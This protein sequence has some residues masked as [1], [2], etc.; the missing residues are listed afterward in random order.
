MSL[1]YAVILALGYIN[2]ECKNVNRS[3]RSK[4]YNNHSND[5]P[6]NPVKVQH[7][8]HNPWRTKF[9]KFD[10]DNEEE[11]N[12]NDHDEDNVEEGEEVLDSE[13]SKT[14]SH[15]VNPTGTSKDDN[16]I[17][18]DNEYK[19]RV[20]GQGKRGILIYQQ[21]DY[22]IAIMGLIDKGTLKLYAGNIILKEISLWNIISP[23]EMAN[24]K[25]FSIR[26]PTQL[27]TILCA[28]GID[29]RN[30]WVNA[31]ESSRLCLITKVK[32][33]LPISIDKDFVEPEDP[34]PSGI[35]VFIAESQFGKPEIVI[36]G[37]TLE[38]I[39]NDE[40]ESIST[41][42]EY[43]T[44]LWNGELQKPDFQEDEFNGDESMESLAE[45]EMKKDIAPEFGHA[46]MF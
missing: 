40:M 39:K 44:T 45:A 21:Q 30:R 38:Q 16:T 33:Y 10:S 15:I 46:R 24:N 42:D 1:W 17:E 28:G 29:S 32:Y 4:V 12:E 37:K 11:G 36:N 23:I 22:G 19:P 26:Q 20:C 7:Q 14:S 31:L 34:P 41:S 18:N 6:I 25:C 43:G 5:M 3:I 13:K 2:S 27:P 35:N 8:K 9:M